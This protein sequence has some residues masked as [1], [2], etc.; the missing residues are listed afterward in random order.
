MASGENDLYALIG[1]LEPK[2]K[3][4]FVRYVKVKAG[5][6]S[7]EP[8][9]LRLYRFL[10]KSLPP[11][12][13]RLKTAFP[14]HLRKLKAYL[15]QALLDALADF[16]AAADQELELNALMAYI[17]IAFQ[18]GQ[19]ALCESL[20]NKAEKRSD[21]TLSDSNG[22]EL[23]VWRQR[24]EHAYGF[25]GL[26]EARI[27]EYAVRLD[28]L[29]ARMQSTTWYNRL[30]VNLFYD[31][32]RGNYADLDAQVQRIRP[33]F[34]A[35]SEA[36]MPPCI[37][38]N[39]QQTYLNA[40]MVYLGLMQDWVGMYEL[41]GKVVELHESNKDTVHSSQEKFINYLGALE[42]ECSI[43]GQLAAY[44]RLERLVEK[45]KKLKFPTS[46]R[47][48]PLLKAKM[49]KLQARCMLEY[50]VQTGRFS[51]GLRESTWVAPRMQRLS[52]QLEARTR[53]DL[54]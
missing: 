28:D 6:E 2:E 31:H 43:L 37:G 27:D 10:E 24:L 22:L 29:L 38:M 14:S 26:N 18:K 52:R 11:D 12:E 51:E 41:Q 46:M 3:A 8:E 47:Q 7:A 42:G 4:H 36:D 48:S 16:H 34:E 9:Y 40:K 17:R 54:L 21:V 19:Y 44:E 32:F 39:A 25:L 33:Y 45:T 15:L 49:F 30:Q 13:N 35:E 50:Y 23:I 53:G 1:S 5:P 20:V